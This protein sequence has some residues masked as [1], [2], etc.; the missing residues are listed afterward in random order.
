MTIF[1]KMWD[2]PSLYNLKDFGGVIEGSV[3]PCQ[4]YA[5]VIYVEWAL[6]ASAELIKTLLLKAFDFKMKA[7]TQELDLNGKFMVLHWKWKI[8][9]VFF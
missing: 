2:D 7:F 9:L 4:L 8:F 3:N 6:Y 5:G 1:P